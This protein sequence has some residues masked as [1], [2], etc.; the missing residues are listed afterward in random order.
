MADRDRPGPPP[1][2]PAAARRL[3]LGAAL[4][5]TFAVPVTLALTDRHLSAAPAALVFSTAAAAL[6]V[7]ALAL[8]PLLAGGHRIAWHRALGTAA[9]VL[10]LAHVGGL[11][12]VE[13]DDTLFALS[14]DGPTRARM[15]L[16]G[17]IA[18]I[19]AV[20][21]GAGR[22]RLP[23]A[24]DTWRILHGFTAVLVIAL[25]FGHA[26]LTDGAL[27]GAGTV[28]LIALGA[29]GLVAIPAAFLRRTRR[30]RRT[31]LGR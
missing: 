28:V 29:L 24:D 11:F 8:Q 27:D 9:F 22:S 2:P 13:V 7:S 31:R 1:G 25:G 26:I 16:L 12:L 21:L 10:V 4:L 19:V 30:G 15:A 14:P 3:A 6:A 20:A 23:L 5:L 17:T 18:L